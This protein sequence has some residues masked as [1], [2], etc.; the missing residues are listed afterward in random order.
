MKVTVEQVELEQVVL[1][2]VQT[3][4]SNKEWNTHRE[5]LVLSQ[6]TVTEL[7]ALLTGDTQ[8]LS[9]NDASVPRP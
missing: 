2:H 8:S 9:V 7:E 4:V 3:V 5:V 6:D 1:V